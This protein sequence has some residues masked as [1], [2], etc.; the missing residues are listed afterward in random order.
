ML[1]VQNDLAIITILNRKEMDYRD[2]WAEHLQR[3]CMYENNKTSFLPGI[4]IFCDV[5]LCN[6]EERYQHFGAI[7]VL[8]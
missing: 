5:V 4:I 7:S 6:L 3:L 8:P 2:W 1:D